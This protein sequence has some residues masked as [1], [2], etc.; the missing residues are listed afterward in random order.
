M[1]NLEVVSV[2]IGYKLFRTYNI[3]DLEVGEA[4]AWTLWL[5]IIPPVIAFAAGTV[6]LLRRKHS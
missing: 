3:S 5:V 1:M 4:D 6:V 2:N